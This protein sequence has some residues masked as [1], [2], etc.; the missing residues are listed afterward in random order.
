VE[1]VILPR[2]LIFLKATLYIEL[3]NI[4]LLLFRIN[5]LRAHP[6]DVEP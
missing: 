5:D 2:I 1:P 4:I 6:F 3:A